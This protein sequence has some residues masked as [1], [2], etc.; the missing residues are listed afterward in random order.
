MTT[1]LQNISG[2]MEVA[3]ERLSVTVIHNHDLEK[4]LRQVEL[5]QRTKVPEGQALDRPSREP[6]GFD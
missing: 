3:P 5:K 6:Y 1:L 4:L 2:P